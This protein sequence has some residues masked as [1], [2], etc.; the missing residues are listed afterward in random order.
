MKFLR[1]FLICGLATS[2]PAWAVYA[3]I[4]EQDQGKAWTFDLLGGISHDSNI[5]G[6][7]TNTI[8]STVYTTS[9]KVSFNAS[10]TDQ[11]FVSASY[12]LTLDHFDNRPGEKTLDSHALMARLA[13]AFSEATTIDLSDDFNIQK[14]PESDLSGL[15]INT[16][17]SFKSNEIDGS[18]TTST[19][20]KTDLT[21]KAQSVLY[22]YDN[23]HLG[24][25]LD[26]TEN[27]FG[28]SGDYAVLPEMKAV[29][30]YRYQVIDYRQAG[31]SKNKFSNFFLVGGDYNV[32][33]ELTV[34][35]RVGLEHR[36][37]DA[38]SNETVPYAEF[39]AKYDYAQGSF[40]SAGYVYDLEETSNVVL[41]TDTQV[42]RFF[43]N[44]QHAVTALIAS[45]A[46]IDFEPSKLNGVRGSPDVNETTTRLGYALSY[47][48]NKNWLVS[49]TY[50]YDKVSSGDPSRGLSR[51]R[52]G[53]NA[54]YTF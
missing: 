40:V 45:S 39:S 33:K 34:S 15:P 25:S 51:N 4:P 32:A 9:P 46:S 17:Q 20:A 44:V 5:F 54:K 7:P 47:L 30:E 6:A 18:F 27:L 42:N 14:N 16:D 10:V 29:A 35:G 28:L 48:P 11:T 53:I 43:V 26:R 37:R 19:T 2:L 41:Y 3:P 50:D 12:Q 8:S 31:G 23:A 13:H 38:E 52:V 24:A 1:L 21:L 49:A 36:N 22:L